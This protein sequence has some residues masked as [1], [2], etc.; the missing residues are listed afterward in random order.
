MVDSRSQQADAAV[1]GSF[2][3]LLVLSLQAAR[4]YFESLFA[5]HQSCT[6]MDVSQILDKF[7]M[8]KARLQSHFF[9]FS[10]EERETFPAATAILAL[11]TF[12]DDTFS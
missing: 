7:W 2:D 4:P 10:V 12:D 5:T 6:V 8:W 11:D 3:K 9:A 1:A